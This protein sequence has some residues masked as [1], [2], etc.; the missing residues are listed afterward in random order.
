[1]EEKD[2][3]DFTPQFGAWDP[4]ILILWKE[5]SQILPN[6]LLLLSLTVSSNKTMHWRLLKA[7][8]KQIQIQVKV[9]MTENQKFYLSLLKNTKKVNSLQDFWLMISKVKLL[10]QLRWVPAW[11]IK[12]SEMMEKSSSFV[13]ELEFYLF[14]IWLTCFSR[15]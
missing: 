3:P 8:F 6:H 14:V 7:S 5:C 9:S 12:T 4:S 1:M 15:E 13:E 11:I 10:Y 2:A